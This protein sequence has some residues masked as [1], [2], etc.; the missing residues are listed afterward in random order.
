M[1]AAF[2]GRREDQRLVT[3]KGQYTDDWNL[4]GQAY[5]YFLRAD[6]AHAEIVSLDTSEA[7]AMPGVLGVFSGEDL[8]KAGYKS[9][10]PLMHFKGKDGSVLRNP[11]RPALAHGRVRF[12]G[13]PVAL[14]VA[15]NEVAAQDAAERI[16][17]DYR[18]LPAIIELDEALA[19]AAPALHD[20][21]PGNLALD[22][23]YGNRAAADEAFAKADRVVTHEAA[24]SAD[25]RRSDGAEIRAR[26]FRPQQ[27][28]ASTS[29]CRP[30]ACPTS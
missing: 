1:S 26:G 20:D 25:F 17:V 6:R 16:V 12:V 4:P 9:P 22:Y 24:C 23:E 13:E 2:K 28:D 18:D 30:R 27:R 14:V 21:A 11:H 19:P 8:A 29:T 5:G 3:G 10:R 15:E 7:S